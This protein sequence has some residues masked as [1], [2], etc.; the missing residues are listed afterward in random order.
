MDQFCILLDQ[1]IYYKPSRS[2]KLFS[3][4]KLN[5]HFESAYNFKK[6]YPHTKIIKN[7]YLN[8]LNDFLSKSN[9]SE[10]IYVLYWMVQWKMEY[11]YYKKSIN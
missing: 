1:H 10:H 8:E 7:N 2:S 5:G 4:L 3:T 11:R 6:I 9:I